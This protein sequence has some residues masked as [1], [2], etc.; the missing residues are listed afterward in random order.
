MSLLDHHA[1]ALE[2]LAGGLEHLVGEVA[3]AVAGGL[4]AGQGAAV[5]Q[6][7]AGEHAVEFVAD[8]LVLAEQVARAPRRR[9]SMRRLTGYAW[10]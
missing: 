5:A 10:T 6:A 8:A 3:Q 4:G 9:K 1:L 7:L 2:G